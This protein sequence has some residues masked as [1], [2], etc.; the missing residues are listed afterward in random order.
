MAKKE[1]EVK[2]VKKEGYFEEAPEASRSKK[3]AEKKDGFVE[4]LCLVQEEEADEDES[5]EMVKCFLCKKKTKGVDFTLDD[6]EFTWNN[7]L[8]HYIRKHDV[9]PSNAFVKYIEK[10]HENMQQSN[11]GDDLFGDGDENGGKDKKGK[12]DKKDKG[13]GKEKK[14]KSKKSKKD[15]GKKEKGKKE[16]KSKEE[17]KKKSRSGKIVQLTF[18]VREL[19]KILSPNDPVQVV[20]TVEDGLIRLS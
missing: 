5:G 17:R 12:K 10:A 16:K 18:T 13:K 19:N 3:W 14:E 7:L 4:K 6:E 8:G 9:K 1:N 20:G 15:K 11:G 2:E